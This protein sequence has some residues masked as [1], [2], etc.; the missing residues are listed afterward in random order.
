MGSFADFI[1]SA[2]SSKADKIEINQVR[3]ILKQR[4]RSC[5]FYPRSQEFGS[6]GTLTRREKSK[7]FKS[8]CVPIGYCRVSLH[9]YF[10]Y[11]AYRLNRHQNNGHW[12]Q[13]QRAF[14]EPWRALA[15]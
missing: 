8:L 3:P 9:N 14:Y 10:N 13:I 2:H 4:M 5:I 11:H 1:G 12:Q 15:E 7:H 6:L